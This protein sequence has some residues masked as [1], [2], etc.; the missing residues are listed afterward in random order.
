MKKLPRPL[1]RVLCIGA[2]TAVLA[3]VLLFDLTY[4]AGQGVRMLSARRGMN[5]VEALLTD[6]AVDEDTREFL[7]LTQDIRRFAVDVL[8]L[9]ETDNYTAYVTTDRNYLVDV[10]S[11]V[12]SDSLERYTRRYPLVGTVFYRGFYNSRGA[13]RFAAR[14]KRRGY[15][16]VVRKVGAYSSLGYLVDP[17]YSYMREYS[18]YRI[19]EMII[20]EMTHATIWVPGNNQFNEEVAT[21]IGRKGAEEYIR[22][23]YGE[24]SPHYTALFPA[25]RDRDRFISFLGAVYSELEEGYRA[26]AGREQRLL[27]KAEILVRERA[28]FSGRYREIYETDTYLW[29]SVRDWDH[30]FLDMYMQYTRDLDIYYGLLEILNGSLPAA[31]DTLIDL[32][33][34][35][36]D[37]KI[38]INAILAGDPLNS[39][40]LP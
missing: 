11:A 17:L 30:A 40:A 1:R 2:F 21:F 13:E 9:E 26:A 16:V 8:G 24:A 7:K 22:L 33:D 10:V 31:V 29:A 25:R 32:F 19:A 28:D 18:E 6:P 5:E 38:A 37:P 27:H 12:R 14:L 15:D 35:V 3:A 23:K 39:S 36:P 34:D 20:H 4:L